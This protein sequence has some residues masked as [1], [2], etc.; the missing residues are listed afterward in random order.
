MIRLPTGTRIV[1]HFVKTSFK[2]A[3]LAECHRIIQEKNIGGEVEI[4]G[5]VAY[6]HPNYTKVG[7]HLFHFKG[8]C[9]YFLRDIKYDLEEQLPEVEL[10]AKRI[11]SYILLNWDCSLKLYENTSIENWSNDFPSDLTLIV[12]LKGNAILEMR[13]DDT[14]VTLTQEKDSL[15]ILGKEAKEWKRRVIAYTN[16]FCTASFGV[17]I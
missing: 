2:P 11:N 8:K 4:G 10:L 5:S 9:P 16:D 6:H 13:R 1:P 7:H 12:T 15:I 17:K 3:K 14:K